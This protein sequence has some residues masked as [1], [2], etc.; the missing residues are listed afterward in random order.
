MGDGAP[1]V[2]GVSGVYIFGDDK[3]M[4][5]KA[6]RASLLVFLRWC[7]FP[8]CTCVAVIHV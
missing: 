7:E 4:I 3:S 2:A 5:F 6:Y 1:D 8:F